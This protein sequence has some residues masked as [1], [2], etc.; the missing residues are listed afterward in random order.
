M[1][2]YEGVYPEKV[3]KIMRWFNRYKTSESNTKNALLLNSKVLSTEETLEVI[4]AANTA[5]KGLLSGAKKS[6]QLIWL[7]KQNHI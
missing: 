2:D 6:R 5:Y 7:N 3:F 1:Q 4:K